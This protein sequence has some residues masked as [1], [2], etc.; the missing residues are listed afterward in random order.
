MTHLKYEEIARLVEGQVQGEERQRFLH[1]ISHCRD[2]SAIYSE[3]AGFMEEDAR[4]KSPFTLPMITKP[5]FRIFKR[6]A[7]EIFSIGKRRLAMAAVAVILLIAVLPFVLTQPGH[8]G[9]DGARAT[10]IEGNI[11][12]LETLAFSP[13]PDE[14]YA[15]IGKGML[16]EDLSLLDTEPPN[17]SHRA[18]LKQK[19]LKLL[20]RQ[21]A[22]GHRCAE[23]TR[24]GR[25]LE[26]SA[27]GTFENKLPEP[28]DIAAYEGLARKYRL[29]RGILLRLKQL[30]TA[31][32]A[33]EYRAVHHKITEIIFD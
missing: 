25:F 5:D 1:H 20:N 16:L 24:F 9:M 21:A 13:A 14:V 32:G 31:R 12:Q 30:Q 6:A 10:H 11:T 29:P 2:C 19:L 8:G 27:L 18:A 33:E 23:L 28:K 7:A 17:L 15:A 3:T 26:R 4:I 22:A